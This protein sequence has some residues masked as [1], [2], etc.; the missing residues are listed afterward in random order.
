MVSAEDGQWLVA[1]P[2]ELMMKPGGHGAIWKLMS[3]YGVFEWLAAQQRSAG[4]VRQISNPIAGTDT[5][6]LALAGAGHSRGKAFGFMSCERTVGAS[7]GMNVLQ[8]RAGERREGNGGGRLPGCT[9]WLA[10]AWG[11]EQAQRLS[12]PAAHRATR[13]PHQRHHHPPP[14]PLR[15]GAAA[16]GAGRPRRRHLAPRLQ[17]DKRRVHRV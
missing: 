10:A 2:C 13:N 15:T 14:A 17:R 9:S 16:V 11:W 8:V 3:D 7:E 1:G 12:A 4:I 5:T 6:L